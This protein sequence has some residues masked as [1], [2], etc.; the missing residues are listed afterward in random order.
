MHWQDVQ[1]QSTFQQLLN[2]I[3]N[4]KTIANGEMQQGTNQSGF[5]SDG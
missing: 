4:V 2:V 5:L 3:Y 1:Q